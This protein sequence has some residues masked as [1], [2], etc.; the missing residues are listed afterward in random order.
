MPAMALPDESLRPL[1]R[2]TRRDDARPHDLGRFLAETLALAAHLV[3]VESGSLL[4]DDPTAK[5]ADRSSGAL[6]LVAA[7]GPAA[8][9][10]LGTRI[11]AHRGVV[12]HVYRT[13]TPYLT[14]TARRDPHFLETIDARTGY[15]TRS[16][17]AAP[18]RLERAVC[19]VL[20]LIN[21]RRGQF[22][23]RDLR[24]AEVFA[25]YFGRAVMN[26]VDAI[27]QGE[28]ALIDDLTGLGN[29]RRLQEQLE[30][31]V[32]AAREGG[33]HLSLVIVDLD[34][35]KRLNDTQ[36]HPAG[37][38]AIRRA[39][40]CLLQHVDGRGSA[41]RLGGDEFVALLPGQDARE[42]A[43]FAEKIR[44]ALPEHTRGATRERPI[45]LPAMRASAGVAS[46]REHVGDDERK[47]TA[48]RLLSAADRALYRAKRAGRDRV[49][50]ATPRD[51]G[52]LEHPSPAFATT[53][54]RAKRPSGSIPKP[55]RADEPRATPRGKPAAR[56]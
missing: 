53:T 44:R 16:L 36:G 45:V 52:P 35:L 3:P 41:F 7:F 10:V 46:L 4:L 31:Q 1:L 47:D 23:P 54:R 8:G 14:S 18:V 12:G 9:A 17:L 40:T 51:G 42:A 19:G 22:T 43:A 28:L 33:H 55:G 21:R 49:R 6:T 26:A 2:R 34:R 25:G 27:K 39:A 37:S 15:R 29:V 24:I 50:L 5:G 20:E 30:V 32:R 13:G 56:K 48:S 38:E 11:S